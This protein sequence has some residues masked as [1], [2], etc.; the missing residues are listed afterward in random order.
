M[1]ALTEYDLL[2][3]YPYPY[4]SYPQSFYASSLPTLNDLS[5]SSHS[6]FKLASTC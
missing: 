6:T 5:I 4:A 1:L 2:A 3:Y